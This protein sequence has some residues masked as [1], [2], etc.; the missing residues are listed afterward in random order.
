[1][2]YSNITHHTACFVQVSAQWMRHRLL[3]ARWCDL[4]VSC[5]LLSSCADMMLQLHMNIFCVCGW[6]NVCCAVRLRIPLL[7]S[8]CCM[9]LLSPSF[10]SSRTWPML[11]PYEAGAEACLLTGHVD[12]RMDRGKV[13]SFGYA[14]GLAVCQHDEK[15]S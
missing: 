4:C 10:A 1:M 5:L 12:G 15:R 9:S 11:C 14:S 3:L 8:V 6:M 7:C 2:R 13:V